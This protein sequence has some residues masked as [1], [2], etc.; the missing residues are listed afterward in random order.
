MSRYYI[1]IIA[2]GYNFMYRAYGAI[3]ASY[4]ICSRIVEVKTEDCISNGIYI[5]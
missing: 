5:I 2:W 3:G 1:I 4:R